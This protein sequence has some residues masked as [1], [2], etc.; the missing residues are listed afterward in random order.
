MINPAMVTA[1][2]QHWHR[3]EAL[4]YLLFLV[5]QAIFVLKLSDTAARGNN[6]VKT[7][8]HYLELNWVTLIVRVFVFELLGFFAWTHQPVLVNENWYPSW[9]PHWALPQYAA[10]FIFLGYCS[11]SALDWIS[12]SPRVPSIIKAQI[13]PLPQG[14]AQEMAMAGALVAPAQVSP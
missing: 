6:G 8:R 1:G 12:T 7:R 13:P 4:C 2:V 11:D 9:A 3:H 10:L 14:G 5:G